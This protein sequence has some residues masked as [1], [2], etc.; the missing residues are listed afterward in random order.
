M[1]RL[2]RR[3]FLKLAAMAPAALAFSQTIVPSPLGM[4]SPNIIVLVFDAMSADNLSLYGYPRKTTPNFERLAQRSTV[5]HSHYSAGTFT[6]PGTASLLTGLYP[7]THRAINYEGQIASAFTERNIFSLVGRSYDRAGFGQNVWAELLLAEFHSD[8][9]V[10]IPPGTFSMKEQLWGSLFTND[11]PIGYY[12]NDSFLYLLNEFPKS[13]IFGLLDRILSGYRLRSISNNGYV[14]NAPSAGIYKIYFRLDEVFQGLYSQVIKFREPFLAYFHLWPPHE[15]YSPRQ[16]FMHVVQD[17]WNPPAKKNHH[18]GSFVSLETIES[19][20]Q[21]YDAYIANVDWEFGR[22]LDVLETS[23]VLNRTYF[24]LTSDHGEMF[25]RG[26]VGHTSPLMY[27]PGLHVPLLIS[28]PGQKIRS[29]IYSQ[30][31]SVD[32]LPTLLKIAG[33]E[34][35]AWAEGQLLPGFGGVEDNS[36]AT[37]SLNANRNSSFG[38][39]AIASIA[40]RKNGYKLIYYKGYTKTDLFELYNLQSDPEELRDLFNKDVSTANAMKDELLS[41]FDQHSGPLRG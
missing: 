21:L 5:Y 6:T 3:D 16:E 12:A 13:L 35:P 22:F 17:G 41:T 28:A 25:E 23:G 1:T 32:D 15:P 9:D 2:S 18:L 10:R 4:N 11:S 14:D 8:L 29:D 40:M 27:D 36:R 31:N 39:L 34:V 26:V 37:Y 30:T 7:W 20:R 24:V 33:R 38:R 19:Q